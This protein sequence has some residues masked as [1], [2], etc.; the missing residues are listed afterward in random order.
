[1]LAAVGVISGAT[2][3]TWGNSLYNGYAWWFRGAG[4]AVL[5]CLTWWSLHRQRACTRAGIKAV[6]GRLLGLLAVGIA[7]YV[8]LYVLTS[9][10]ERFA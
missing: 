3:L 4:L 9:W 10:L 2:A 1:M 7:T 5:I 6:R 8:G